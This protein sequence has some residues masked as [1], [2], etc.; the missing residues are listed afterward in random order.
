MKMVSVE[1]T[2]QGRRVTL[3]M[4]MMAWDNPSKNT[5]RIV[6]HRVRKQA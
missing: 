4:I 5:S 6:A 2:P 1:M 3:R